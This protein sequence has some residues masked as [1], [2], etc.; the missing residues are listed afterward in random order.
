MTL[1]ELVGIIA[2]YNFVTLSNGPV[3]VAM[4]EQ[5]LVTERH[6]LGIDQLLFAFT[7]GRVTPGPASSYVSAIGYLMHGMLGAALTTAAI[8]APGYLVLPMMRGYERIKNWRRVQGFID[9]LVA[10]QVGLIFTA[11]MRLGHETMTDFG[12]WLIAAVT[13]V[14]VHVLERSA[15]LALLAA[16]VVG[17]A[18]HFVH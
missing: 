14:I 9:G 3:M 6:A 17:L 16:A 8:V 4:L 11:I 5:T 15:P 18:L 2:V 1:F 12:A 13:F 10:A 7:V